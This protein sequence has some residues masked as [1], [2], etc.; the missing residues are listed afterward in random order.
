MSSGTE[1][2]TMTAADYATALARFVTGET[3]K[4]IPARRNAKLVVFAW[5]VERFEPERSYTDPPR[6]LRR[7]LHGS[8]RRPILAH[9]R[10]SAPPTHLIL[11]PRPCSMSSRAKRR[12]RV[13]EGPRSTTITP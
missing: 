2:I 5:L 6:P 4:V 1:T 11:P 12:R 13:V 8:C 9:P 10:R 7:T 3:L